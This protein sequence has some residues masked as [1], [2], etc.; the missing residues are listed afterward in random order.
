MSI[1][2]RLT[3]DMCCAVQ[4]QMLQRFWLIQAQLLQLHQQTSGSWSRL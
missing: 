4:H 1:W 2:R 3:V